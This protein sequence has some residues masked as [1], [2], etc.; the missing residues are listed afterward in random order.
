ML[1]LDDPKWQTLDGGYKIPY[2]AS[3]ALKRLERGEDVWD[4]LW[5]ELHHQGDVGEASYAA[6]PHL[7]R[8]GKTLAKRDWNLYTLVSCIEDER[9]RKTNPPLPDWLIESYQQAMRE[10]LDLASRDIQS[11]DEQYTVW[12]ILGAI[13]LA[14]GQLRLGALISMADESE[15]EEILEETD[16]WS[17]TYRVPE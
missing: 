8:I 7:I 1:S 4:D 15:V 16:P 3:V 2:D 10:L 17:E 13:A 9:H 14:K 11:A 6:V 12:S 5:E